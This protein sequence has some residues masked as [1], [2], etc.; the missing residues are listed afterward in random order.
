MARMAYKADYLVR[1]EDNNRTEVTRQKFPKKRTSP[2]IGLKRHEFQGKPGTRKTFGL[3]GKQG[4]ATSKGRNTKTTA[5]GPQSGERVA[6]KGA[7]GCFG[8]SRG[9]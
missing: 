1:I 7:D 8:Q 4:T 3:C 5:V 9:K 2:L 6:T